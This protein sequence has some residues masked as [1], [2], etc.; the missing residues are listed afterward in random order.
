MGLAVIHE[1]CAGIDV[2]KRQVTV[3]V[4]VQAGT[5]RGSSVRLIIRVESEQKGD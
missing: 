4:Q 1:H 2:H 3:C 5:R